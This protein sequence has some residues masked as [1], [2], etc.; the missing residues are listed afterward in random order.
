MR[1]ILIGGSALVA[2][3][4]NVGDIVGGVLRDALLRNQS[5]SSMRTVAAPKIHGASLLSKVVGLLP[6]TQC[7]FFS[8]T[9]ALLSPTGQGNYSSSNAQLD[10]MASC[11]QEMGM[12]SE[13]CLL[14]HMQLMTHECTGLTS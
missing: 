11:M 2:S 4:L 5:P 8:S 6:N 12:S 13:T 14:P 3:M 9:S 1:A 10:A 7:S